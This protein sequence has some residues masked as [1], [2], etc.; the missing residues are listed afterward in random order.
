MV[1][2]GQLKTENDIMVTNARHKNSLETAF[3]ACNDALEAL[4]QN[5][6]L[7]IVET[8]FKIAW[9]SLGKITGDTVS[10]DLLDTIFR[11]FCIGK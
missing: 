6:E 7:D 1:Y 5:I 8:D 2:E 9:D 10:E 11:E 3:N 4:G